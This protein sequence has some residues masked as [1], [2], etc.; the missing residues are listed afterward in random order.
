MLD[1]RPGLGDAPATISSY[2]RVAQL[3]AL[4]PYWRGGSIRLYTNARTPSPTDPYYVYVEPAGIW[5]QP[6][7]LA[8]LADA[9]LND[10]GVA[11][12]QSDVR[13]WTL[14][15]GQPSVTI[16]GVFLTDHTGR[17]WAA[18]PAPSPVVLAA[19]APTITAQLVLTF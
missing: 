15:A 16:Q 1:L 17:L 7:V 14:P 11:Q 12:T 2:W 13:T 5:Y 10:Q 9:A 4:L 3:D 8:D 6:Q 18:Q 19:D